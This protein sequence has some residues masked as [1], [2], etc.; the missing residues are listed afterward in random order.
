MHDTNSKGKPRI[1]EFQLERC[2]GKL[3]PTHIYSDTIKIIKEMLA[4]EGM[5]GRFGNILNTRDFFPESF[6]LSIYWVSRKYFF[7][8]MIFLK[9][10]TATYFNDFHLRG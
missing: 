8:I 2:V 6:F 5:E 3:R 7:Y 1:I 4:E 9:K 10:R